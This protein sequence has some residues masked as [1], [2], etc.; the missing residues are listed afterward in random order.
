MNTTK[1]KGCT[2]T[3]GESQ[4]YLGLPLKDTVINDSVTGPGTPV[5]ES[6]WQPSAEDIIKMMA[7]NPIK[8]RV[9]GTVH[10]PVMIEVAEMEEIG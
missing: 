3:I 4:G 5:M 10:P 6:L 7:G 2:R 8:L 1:I 9:V